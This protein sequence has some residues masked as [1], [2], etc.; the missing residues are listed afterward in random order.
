MSHLIKVMLQVL[1][2]RMRNKMLPEIPDTQFGFIAD[3]GT[4]NAILGF[5][6]IMER[7][8]RSTERPIPQHHCLF[9]GI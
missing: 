1:M 3:K 9:P 5:R 4:R 2:N 6:T 7:V 8:A